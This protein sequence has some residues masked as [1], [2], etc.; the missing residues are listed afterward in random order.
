[1]WICGGVIVASLKS[2]NRV[3][4]PVEFATFTNAQIP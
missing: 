3:Q 4:T 2:E 1:M